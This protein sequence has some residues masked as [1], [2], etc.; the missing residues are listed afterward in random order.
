MAV[1][2]PAGRHTDG[3]IIR[4]LFSLFVLLPGGAFCL[5]GIEYTANVQIPQKCYRK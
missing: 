2:F 1:V 3:R 4:F 5:D